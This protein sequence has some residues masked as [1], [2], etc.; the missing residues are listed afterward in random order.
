MDF[1][2]SIISDLHAGRAVKDLA[3]VESTHSV[4]T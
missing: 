2:A 1:K 4:E 3:K